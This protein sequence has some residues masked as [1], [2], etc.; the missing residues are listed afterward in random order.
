M[1]QAWA[2]SQTPVQYCQS[3]ESQGI[4]TCIAV[5]AAK[6]NESS[7]TNDLY[8]RISAVFPHRLGWAAFGTGNAMEGSLMFII[9]PGEGEHGITVSV[10]TTQ[11]EHDAPQH[12]DFLPRYEVKETTIVD[13]I[14]HEAVIVCYECDSYNT[15]SKLDVASPKQPWIW[16][17]E[18]KQQTQSADT[19]I[20]LAF[21]SGFGSFTLNMRAAVSD[22]PVHPDSPLLAISRLS[23]NVD[24]VPDIR[25]TMFKA[26]GIFL[27][28]AFC[29]MMPIAS[30]IIRGQVE[31]AFTKHSGL[32]MFTIPTVIFGI[33]I[34]LFFSTWNLSFDSRGVHKVIGIFLLFTTIAQPILGWIHHQNYILYHGRTA[35]S[36]WHIYLGRIT[37]GLGWLNV[38]LGMIIGHASMEPTF[39]AE[40]REE[41]YELVGNEER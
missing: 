34:A 25:H 40:D 11:V 36:Y 14:Y 32:Q 29:V 18:T 38:M 27:T 26:H 24:E 15:S 16:A 20:P 31:S 21:H 22:G 19:S 5:V 17:A 3:D 35:V 37:V 33:S 12:E 10:R 2:R 7:A 6:H 23:H 4:D 8:I 28:I 39:E 9:Y 1:S 13:G 30:A 41:R